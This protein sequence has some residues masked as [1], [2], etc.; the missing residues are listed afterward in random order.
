MGQIE[1]NLSI[2]E[3]NMLVISIDIQLVILDYSHLIS[4][5]FAMLCDE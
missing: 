4:V 2:I 3:Q 1:A 5:D